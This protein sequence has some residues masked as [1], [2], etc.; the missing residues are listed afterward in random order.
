MKTEI[1]WSRFTPQLNTRNLVV[2]SGLIV[3][4][5]FLLQGNTGF[6]L[7]DEGFLWYGTIRTALGEVPVRDFQSYEP[8]RYYWGALWFKLL[9]NDGILALR[10]SQAVFQFIGLTLGLLLLRR[11]LGSWI[12]L[13]FAAVILVRWLF[14]TWKI[15]EPVIL[16]AAIYFA[17]LL[18][19][20][21]SQRRHLT[22]GIFVGLAAFFGRN[23]GLYCGVAFFLLTCYL[24]WTDKRVLLQ[25]VAT[26]TLG[27][28]IG[29]LPML[30][31]LAFV[32]G[33]F[34]QVAADL[35]FNLK[36][37]TNL[38]L[39]VPWPWRHDYQSLGTR[40]AINRV[41]VGMLYLAVPAFYVFALARLI[42]KRS[43]SHH[44][45][46]VACAFVGTVYLHYTFARPQLFYLAWTIP[47][48]IFGLVALP[49]SFTGQLNRKIAMG[50]WVILAL[51]TITTLEMAEEN[52]FTIKPKAFVKARL[53]GRD[54]GS[55]DQSM[56][57]Q[58]LLKTNVRG[59]H[60]WV[61]RDT[62]TLM[63]KLAP[64]EAELTKTNA[65][66][67]VAPYLPG[68]YATLG[69]SSP[70]WEIY[71]LLPRPLE[72]QQAMVQDLE[73][74]Q[75]NWALVCNHYVD[76]R[77]ELQFS[78]TH[79]LVWNYLIANFEET[80]RVDRDCSLM[81]RSTFLADVWR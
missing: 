81:R 9:Q 71:F 1:A 18:I 4:L 76:D 6:N 31:M 50:V 75:V 40:E 42:F 37:G 74:K 2:L 38:P 69:K 59:D 77:P 19:E 66:I 65:N 43:V 25:R 36:Y 28:V 27:A 29:Y 44:P 60:I 58:G 62:A 70:L 54:G 3:A 51:F 5:L 21:P 23:H 80:S 55:F 47:P 14:P 41:A 73:R 46:F 34:H 15:Y 39:P 10:V 45:I 68:L 56:N 79:G 72:E 24:H 35:V 20:Q 30:L 12:A 61:L 7:S 67:L 32:S 78:N 17:V 33:F 64:F 13:L 22:A 53:L 52:Y 11:L 48:F 63:E 16:I 49:A 57:A 8:G 26:L